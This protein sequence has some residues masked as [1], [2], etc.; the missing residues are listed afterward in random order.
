MDHL[1]KRK[2]LEQN[3]NFTRSHHVW[4]LWKSTDAIMLY[5][6]IPD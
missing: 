4:I 3:L 6:I 1:D 5:G 2:E